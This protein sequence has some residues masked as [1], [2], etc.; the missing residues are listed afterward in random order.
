M[1]ARFAN[2]QEIANWNKH[3]LSNPD[4][5]NGFA[6]YEFAMIK[7]LGGYKPCFIFVDN[8]AITVLQKRALYFSRL[9]YLPKGPGV[10]D[11]KML[12]EVLAAL[13]PL[14]KKCGVFAIRIEPELDQSQE[15]ALRRHGL[16]KAHPILPNSSTIIMDISASLDDIMT[17]LPQKGRHAIKR[18]ERDGVIVKQVQADEKNCRLMYKLLTQT[19]EGRFGPRDY[20]YYKNYWQSFTKAEAGQ[21]FFAYSGNKVV[22]GAFAMVFGQKSIYKDGASLRERPVYGASHLLQWRV[23]EWAKSKGSKSHDLCGTPPRSEIGNPDHPFYGIGRFKLS[24]AKT[25][26]DFVGCY[27]YIIN[28]LLHKLWVK[29][30]EKVAHRLYWAKHHTNYY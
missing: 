17:A 12:W 30:G 13:K 23:I 25:V 21:L 26:T 29:F 16:A 4:G 24:F 2:K 18:A 9:W 19:A 28:P 3:V 20:T 5:G 10:T 7:K 8:V 6:S 14:A 11:N 22:A 15:T 1:K 27:D